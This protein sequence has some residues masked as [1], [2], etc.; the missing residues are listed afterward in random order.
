MD[1]AALGQS[2]EDR[3]LLGKVRRDVDLAEPTHRRWR[4]RANHFYSLYRNYQDF[5]DAYTT[6]T[7]RG[8]D[9]VWSDGKET[10]GAGYFIPMAF[11]TV[12]TVVPKVLANRPSMK[13]KPRDEKSADNVQNIEFL[14]A[15]QQEQMRYEL[16][17]Q[18]IAKTGLI[19]GLG[20]QKIAWQT[21]Y[22]KKRSLV[23]SEAGRSE[24]PS[25]FAEAE[26][27]VK[28]YDDPAAFCIDPFDFI[29]DPQGWD[30][31][32]CGYVIHRTW[33]NTD[34]VKQQIE[35]GKWRN[36]DTDPD[37]LRRLTSGQ[38]YDEIWSQRLAAGGFGDVQ[39]KGDRRLHE[40]LEW[41]DGN[42]VVI[43]LDRQVVVASGNN[44]NWHGEKPFQIYRP[45]H[46][47]NQ[48]FGIGEIEP[49]EDLQEEMNTMRRQ[50]RDNASFVL[51]KVVAYAD[52]MVEQD[53]LQF[54]PGGAIPTDGDPRELLFPINTGDIP[55][56]GYQEE[57]RLRADF[58]RTTGLSDPVQG[59]GTSGQTATAAQL[60][61]QTVG[62]RIKNKTLRLELEIIDPGTQ[63]MAELD[64]QHIIEQRQVAIP[65]PQGPQV[66]QYDSK[67]AL[68]GTRLPSTPASGQDAEQR[69]SWKK[70]GPAEL[71]GNFS[72]KAD[73]S[74]TPDNVPQMRSDAEMMQ[75]LF[76]DNPNVDPRKIT[77]KQLELAGLANPEE[78][79]AAPKPEVPP[80]VLDILTQNYGVNPGIISQ[81]LNEALTGQTPPAGSG[82]PES[83]PTNGGPVPAG[84]VQ[85]G[86][87]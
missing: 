2:P 54:V 47:P 41:H 21:K 14:V 82:G 10:F 49:I 72:W 78:F 81:A 25:G 74:T 15:A 71:A 13:A 35:L 77:R 66:P 73:G 3:N 11:S 55:Y 64:Q 48:F 79:L 34:Y 29:W 51:Q 26:Q 84:A 60:M 40:V 68:T 87:Q 86:Q 36:L 61:F 75:S 59:V 1:P 9:A 22:Q 33:R 58:D 85:G 50:R 44:P 24:N 39:R 80:E 28:V 63:Q 20:V 30:V 31:E 62:E 52:G 53:D 76:A 7:E 46:L 42:E 38:K 16:K 57:D 17:L 32:S 83:A 70:L 43:T 67:G 45:T 56:S 4:E 69:W 23:P 19:Y 5:R 27:L 8:R 18:E 12:E 65:A 37:L 6:A